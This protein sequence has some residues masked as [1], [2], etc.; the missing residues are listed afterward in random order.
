MITG[1]KYKVCRRL[2]DGVYEKCQ[3][4]AFQQRKNR[5]HQNL[6]KK[7]RSGQ[8]SDFANAL[9]EK[10]RVRFGYGIT[11]RQMG[12]YVTKARQTGGNVAENLYRLLESRLDNVVYRAGLAKTRRLARQLVSH[13]HVTVNGRRVTIPS[14][15]ITQ[16]EAVA[17]RPESKDKGA[18]TL[19]KEMAK[20]IRTPAWLSFDPISL[21]ADVAGA[22]VFD[23]GAEGANFSTVIGFYSRV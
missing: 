11:E 18:F 10:Q 4:P 5:G 19:V 20:D 13:G 3:L 17:V 9:I 8:R 12:N 14:R 16:G 2:G 23:P 22:P 6:P 7:H 15:H 1:P 21:K